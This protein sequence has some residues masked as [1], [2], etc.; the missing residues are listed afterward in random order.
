M[1]TRDRKTRW[2]GATL[3][4]TILM[5][6]ATQARA[7]FLFIRIEPPAE[8]G[9]SAEVFFSEQAEAGDPKFVAKIAHTKLWI[10]TRPGEF[11]ELPVR[12]AADRLLSP[13]PSDRTLSVVGEC[14]Y[15]VLARPKQVPF[16]LRYYPKA[17]AGNPDELNRLAPRREIPFEIQPTF[18]IH[19]RANGKPAEDCVRLVAL[20][21]GKPVPN[22]TFISVDSSL[23][24]QTIKAGP[25]GT[26]SWNPPAPGNYSVYTRET[27][28]QPGTLGENRYDEIREFATLAMTWPL[29]GH[30]ANPEAVALFKEAIAHRAEWRDF[31]GFSAKLSGHLDRRPFT[32]A[33]T[34]QKDGSVELQADDPTA[35]AWLQDQLDSLVLHR[36]AQ[37]ASDSANTH[38]PR[39]RFADEADDHPLGRLLAV[40][41]DAMGSSYRIK[42]RQITVVNRRIGNQNMTITVLDSDKNPEGRFLPHSYVV[43]YWDAATGKLKRVETFQER[44]QRVGSWDLPVMR[45]ILT[46]SESGLSVKVVAFS[47]H[48]LLGSK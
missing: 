12:R 27:L 28:K 18:E 44:S 30:D 41:G 22:A 43:N 16:L 1:N 37:P 8:A 10:Q 48:A 20:R 13:L 2:V 5:S 24:E 4:A 14:E 15:G 34:V 23:S 39:L 40:E 31:P 36:L 6:L 11:R 3:A 35:K 9:R 47:K 32:G 38:S 46:A 25:D 21:N 42:D 17:V 7:H 29:E 19:E 33:V 26:A 45:S